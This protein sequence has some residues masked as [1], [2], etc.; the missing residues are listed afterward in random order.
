MSQPLLAVEIAHRAGSLR[1]QACF[2]LASERAAL[3][4]PSGTGKTTLLRI[5]A[6]LVVPD[7]GRIAL[8]GQVLTD[9]AHG[10]Q[11]KPGTARGVG[12]ATQSPSLFPHLSVERN[13]RFGLRGIAGD[14]QEERVAEITQL[15]ELQMLARRRPRA[16]SGGERQRAAL[17]R[18]LAPHPRLLLLDEPFSALDAARKTALWSAL[19][20]YLRRYRIATLL[21]SHDA[22]EVWAGAE[23]VVRMEDGAAVRQ[24]PAEEMLAEERRNALRQFGV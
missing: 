22:G 15:L 20:P 2:T 13:I 6:G 24:G 17:G 5:L 23:S 3:F 16:L 1:L 14:A 4:G 21:V 18:A 7:E 12:I 9:R 11:V 8:D 10:V 19:D